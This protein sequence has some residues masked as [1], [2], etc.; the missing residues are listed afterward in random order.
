MIAERRYQLH[1]AAE[2]GDAA[3]IRDLTS[4]PAEG[5]AF[6]P[7]SYIADID[8]RDGDKCMPLH[9]AILARQLDSVVACLDAGANIKSALQGSPVLHVALSVGSVPAN[10]D[11]ALACVTT[12]LQRG[13]DPC[14]ED[15]RKRTTLHLSA[16]YDLGDCA[17]AILD[18]GGRGLLDQPDRQG[19]C[20]C[21]W[22]GSC[23]AR[24]GTH[25]APLPSASSHP[26]RERAAG[27]CTRCPCTTIRGRRLSSLQYVA[28]RSLTVSMP[29]THSPQHSKRLYLYG[30]LV[31]ISAIITL[32]LT[33]SCSL[34]APRP[35]TPPIKERLRFTMR[36][37]TA[38]WT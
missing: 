4:R 19:A 24:G 32:S 28:I 23:G 16:E 15:D 30:P 12:L 21:T 22:K 10:R 33:H 13:A 11:F 36:L 20:A 3:T 27:G 31:A 25:T 6:D 18:N 7:Y 34:P 37:C 1:D 14:A 17:S 5:G 35:I 2:S 9:V 26:R 38:I 8:E 29:G